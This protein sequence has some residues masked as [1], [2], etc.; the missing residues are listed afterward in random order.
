MQ[1]EIP[2]IHAAYRPTKRVIAEEQDTIVVVGKAKQ[3]RKRKVEKKS[4]VELERSLT[5]TEGAAA[6][7]GK[8]AEPFDFSAA[9]NILDDN[10]DI[11]DANIKRKRQRKQNKGGSRRL[12]IFYS[13]SRLNTAS[14]TTRWRLLWRLRGTS[15][16]A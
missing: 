7:P 11:E 1:V 12:Q 10:P 13:S 4:S 2:F 5:V 8:G 16:G 14:F 6:T 9:P 15:K 3:K